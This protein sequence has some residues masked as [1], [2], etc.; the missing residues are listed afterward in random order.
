MVRLLRH[1]IP[2]TYPGRVVDFPFFKPFLYVCSNGRPF[3]HSLDQVSGE[4]NRKEYRTISHAALMRFDAIL[5]LIPSSF[6]FIGLKLYIF[7][8]CNVGGFQV[9]FHGNA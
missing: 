2:Y 3:L 1:P 6:A 7:N 5:F 9:F 8:I 4:H